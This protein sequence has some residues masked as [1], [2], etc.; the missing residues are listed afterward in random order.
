[1]AQPLR[2][3]IQVSNLHLDA[4]EEDIKVFVNYIISDLFWR[5]W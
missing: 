5:V 4:T 2:S 1:M 3:F